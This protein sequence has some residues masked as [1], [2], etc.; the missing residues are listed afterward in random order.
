M[1]LPTLHALL[2]SSSRSSGKVSVIAQ[3]QLWSVA[4]QKVEVP[5]L[6]ALASARV[7]GLRVQGSAL[8]GLAAICRRGMALLQQH[9]EALM[10]GEP[11]C[12]LGSESGVINA[13]VSRGVLSA[14][15]KRGQPLEGVLEAAVR[16]AVRHGREADVKLAQAMLSHHRLGVLEAVV[17]QL[18]GLVPGA[19]IL[20]QQ[21]QQQVM[22]QLQQLQL[23]H[24]ASDDTIVLHP[25]PHIVATTALLDC[26]VP[27]AWQAAVA[28]ALIPALPITL[29]RSS[30]ADEAA[31]VLPLSAPLPVVMALTQNSST[32][33]MQSSGSTSSSQDPADSFPVGSLLEAGPLEAFP[34]AGQEFVGRVRWL[35]PQL[36]W[37]LLEQVQRCSSMW[38]VV[39]E[40]PLDGPSLPEQHQQQHQH[41]QHLA[42]IK[43]AL[44]ASRLSLRSCITPSLPGTMFVGCIFETLP[45]LALA[46]ASAD[47]A[48]LQ[49][50]TQP[51]ALEAA[52]KVWTERAPEPCA[53]L[54]MDA[55]CG[56]AAVLLWR[57][58]QVMAGGQGA[59]Q[60]AAVV[61]CDRDQAQRL[62]DSLGQAFP[63]V[64]LLRRRVLV[65]CGKT[66]WVSLSMMPCCILV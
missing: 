14:R 55:A 30:V 1:L 22:W 41:Q 27:S 45:L 23:Q 5:L 10:A 32:S 15:P 3:R 12:R 59:G 48:L 9:A 6:A 37:K 51:C 49:A 8:R 54:A 19:Q 28:G 35:H 24:Q 25:I 21:Q 17:S 60:L 29:S 38:R 26:G 57:V 50:L 2:L 66:G 36:P 52:A 13:L 56:G 11:W 63:A 44:L 46:W 4:Y 62:V 47:T 34:G 40:S 20:Q 65:A 31:A 16:A 61:G 58:L 42:N 64:A 33:S 53:F 43:S 7:Q 18:L 39:V